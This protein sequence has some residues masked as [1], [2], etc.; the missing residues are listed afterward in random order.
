MRLSPKR[1]QGPSA[2]NHCVSYL[3]VNELA[4]RCFHSSHKQC[5]IETRW[6]FY[7]QQRECGGFSLPCELISMWGRVIP[8]IR[9][10]SFFLFQQL[11]DPGRLRHLRLQRKPFLNQRRTYATVWCVCYV[12]LI[13]SDVIGDILVPAKSRMLYFYDFKFSFISLSHHLVVMSCHQHPTGFIKLFFS[14]FLYK[15]FV[16]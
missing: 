7:C 12:K 13:G 8:T 16:Q 10:F 14:L 9:N 5:I 2:W 1:T 4:I 6:W 11:A 3:W 15:S